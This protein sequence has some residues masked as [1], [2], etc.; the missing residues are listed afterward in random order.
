MP[1]RAEASKLPKWRERFVA[2]ILLQGVWRNDVQPHIYCF[3]SP[4]ASGLMVRDDCRSRSLLSINPFKSLHLVLSDDINY[5][6]PHTAEHNFRCFHRSP[7]ATLRHVN[8]CMKT[9]SGVLWIKEYFAFSRLTAAHLHNS[10]IVFYIGRQSWRLINVSS[11]RIF[12]GNWQ[13]WFLRH[14]RATAAW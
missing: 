13:R 8:S 11:C 6:F 3:W 14:D 7:R 10:I 2:F 4:K 9:F 1:L 12:W 5:I